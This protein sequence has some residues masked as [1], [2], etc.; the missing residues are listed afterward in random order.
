MKLLCF[1]CPILYALFLSA[2]PTGGAGRGYP[3]DTYDNACQYLYTMPDRP[4]CLSAAKVY[5]GI[6]YQDE[7]E[8]CRQS[9]SNYVDALDEWYRCVMES[10]RENYNL[11]LDQ[12]KNTLSC[13][14][15]Q[16]PA[17]ILERAT[18]DCPEVDV[19]IDKYNN[20]IS[21]EVSPLCVAQKKFF[22]DSR[23]QVESCMKK[24]MDY[25]RIMK[26]SISNASWGIRQQVDDAANEAI[27][28]FNCYAKGESYCP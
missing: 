10:L 3:V 5:G 20:L 2:S 1:L 26:E 19:E 25:L 22:P 15:N 23:F 16:I 28:K 11:Y 18:V 17:D 14:D 21:H 13:M 27:R 4:F 7:F 6:K 9:V 12:S 24:V 8:A